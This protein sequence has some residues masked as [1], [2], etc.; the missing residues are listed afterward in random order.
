MER[1][2]MEDPHGRC[3]R[4]RHLHPA[5]PLAAGTEAGGG[6]GSGPGGLRAGPGA[7]VRQRWPSGGARGDARGRP[8]RARAAGP[9]RVRR[10]RRARRRP[11]ARV[12]HCCRGV[13]RILGCSGRCAAVPRRS[14]A[15]T[16]SSRAYRRWRAPAR[17]SCC[18]T[19]TRSRPT[20]A[21]V[22]AARHAGGA[23]AGRTVERSYAGGRGR[24]V[25]RRGR[26][27]AGRGRR[28]LGAGSTCCHAC[29]KERRRSVARSRSPR[30]RAT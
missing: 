29:P 24:A 22:L 28:T 20:G 17:R 9:D 7:G 15:T 26:L 13:G 30:P 25:L 5:D 11:G 3:D 2:L 21:A 19:H 27:R 1:W 12:R 8:R 18:R 14:R 6:S 10:G 4:S 16:A 23:G